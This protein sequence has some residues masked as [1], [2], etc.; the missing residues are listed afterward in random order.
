[1]GND[2]LSVHNKKEEFDNRQ[3]AGTLLKKRKMPALCSTATIMRLPW[4]DLG[5]TQMKSGVLYK[6]VRENAV[7]DK[8]IGFA[9]IRDLGGVNPC[10]YG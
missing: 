10:L 1:M 2:I 3:Q 6:V 8:N 7:T 4:G 5:S 9:R